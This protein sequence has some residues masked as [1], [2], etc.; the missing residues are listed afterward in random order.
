MD[1]TLAD[2]LETNPASRERNRR[3]DITSAG[4]GSGFFHLPPC[5]VG[6]EA[7]SAHS[8]AF[9]KVSWACKVSWCPDIGLEPSTLGVKGC[10]VGRLV[11][12]KAAAIRV[13]LA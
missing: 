11:R 6:Q 7:G 13:L 12:I 4:I 3:Q 5:R 9:R 1:A 2:D 8:L 10:P